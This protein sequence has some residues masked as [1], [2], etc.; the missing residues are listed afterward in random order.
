[1]SVINQIKKGDAVYDIQDQNAIE[2]PASK[3]DGQLLAYSSAS[4]KWVAQNAAPSGVQSVTAAD[5][6]VTVGGTAADPTV[7]AKI[8]AQADNGLSVKADG[9]YAAATDLTPVTTRLTTVEG[10]VTTIEGKE[11]GWDAKYDKPA[12]GIPD[13]DIASAATWNAKQD[14]IPENTYDAYGAA[15]TAEGNAKSYAAGLAVNY[16]TAAQG[17]KADTAL[18]PANI[19]TGSANGA[20]SVNG[21]DVAVKGLGSAAYTNSDAY[22]GASAQAVDSAKLENHAASYFATDADM[23]AAEG[24]IEAIEGKIPTEASPTNQL[25][26]KSFVNSSISTNTATFRGTSAKGLTEEAFLDWANGLTKTNN[27]YVFWDTTDSAS[28]PIFKRYKYNGTAWV[29]EYTLNNSSFTAA[30]WAAVNSG[31][32][33]ADKTKLDG[34]EDGANNYVHPAG[35]AASQASGLYKFSTDANSHVASVTAVAKSDI[36]ALGIPAQ[37]TTYSEATTSAAGLMS[38]ADKT[39]LN[40]VTNASE[41]YFKLPNASWSSKAQTV[42]TFY[43]DSAMTTAVTG[44]ITASTIGVVGVAQGCSEAAYKGAA[45]AQLRCTAQNS[46]SLTFYYYGSAAPGA[47]IPCVLSI[48]KK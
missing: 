9:L 32:A 24:K 14:A 15:A 39:K 1:M 11:A 5:N 30:Q 33:A 47:D 3:S 45:K 12:S 19:T 40:G 34:I 4:G 25:A 6:S 13:A 42:T 35:A 41:I 10:K 17:A 38:A 22:L 43:S 31:L 27:D 18:Q 29:Y 44:V 16:A 2:N 8:S 46:D 48:V 28:N 37:D 7:A 23:T 26:D 36:T 21:A 20:I